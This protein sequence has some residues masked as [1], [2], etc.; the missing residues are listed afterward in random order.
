MKNQTLLS[1][2]IGLMMSASAQAGTL[3]IFCDVQNDKTCIERSL[4]ALQKMGCQTIDRQSSCVAEEHDLDICTIETTNCSEPTPD[5]VITT[6][7][8]EG[9]KISLN[10]FD[11][12][13]TLTWWMGFQSY[14]KSICVK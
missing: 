4:G 5:L 11:R 7:C 6:T 10:K 14:Q 1:L 8:R 2:F 3:N 9:K 12:G 13:L